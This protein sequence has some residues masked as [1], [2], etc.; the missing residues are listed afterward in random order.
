M[1]GV[2]YILLFSPSPATSLSK[3]KP[4]RELS[5]GISTRLP[6][7]SSNSNSR[8]P[9]CCVSVGAPRF[10]LTLT[11]ITS[12][13]C[14][15]VF[16]SLIAPWCVYGSRATSSEFS[17][18]NESKL[19]SSAKRSSSISW[20]PSLVVDEIP[21]SSISTSIMSSSF[22]FFHQLVVCGFSSASSTIVPARVP[23]FKSF[24]LSFSCLFASLNSRN[25]I[26]LLVS[27]AF[28]G[29]AKALSVLSLSNFFCF[30]SSEAYLLILSSFAYD[31][32]IVTGPP[33][34]ASIIAALNMVSMVPGRRPFIL[35]RNSG[36]SSL[37]TPSLSSS[38]KVFSMPRCLSISSDVDPRAM[39]AK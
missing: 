3:T 30:E 34:T 26:C 15:W 36:I 31:S 19:T 24:F 7:A 11:G 18:S 21:S 17:K 38:T 9:S 6:C 37:L 4:S 32:M 23:S 33:T 13:P 1:N 8:T 2:T 29:S 35:S 12:I 25:S 39:S 20:V 14:I 16:T 5:A 22:V 10:E 27:L 28:S